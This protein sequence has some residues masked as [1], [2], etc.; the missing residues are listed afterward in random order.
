MLSFFGRDFL[1]GFKTILIGLLLAPVMQEPPAQKP[2]PPTPPPYVE[3]SQKQ[4]S[5]YPGGKLEISA[6]VP[7][8]VKVIGWERA[9]VMMETEKIISNLPEDKAKVLSDQYPIHLRWNQT[10]V[11]VTTSGPLQSSATMEINVTLYVPKIRTDVN[12]K[13]IQGD[14][15]ISVLNGWVEASLLAGSIEVKSVS[16]YFSLTTQKGDVAIELAGKRW[17]GHSLTAATRQGNIDLKLPVDYSAALQLET[18][19]GELSI[20]YPEQL[21]EGEKVP[22]QATT[23]KAGHSLRAA[24]GDGG[25]PINLLTFAG[26]VHLSARDLP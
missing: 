12:V 11:I 16:G 13:M 20:Q 7:G 10:S 21:V 24:V 8:D 5:F 15:H 23:L 22:L 26:N 9:S 3:R 18:H 2:A 25:A 19:N 1:M 4:F 14:F 17:N 6:G